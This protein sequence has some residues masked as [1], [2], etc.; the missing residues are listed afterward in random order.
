MCVCVC[1][2]VRAHVCVCVCVCVCVSY[3]SSSFDFINY[4]HKSCTVILSYNKLLVTT[5]NRIHYYDI[6][7]L[8]IS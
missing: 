7:Y 4:K 1:V 2:C 8:F 3:Y 5:D 6:L